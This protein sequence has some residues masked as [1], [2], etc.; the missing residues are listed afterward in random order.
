M[1]VDINIKH[2]SFHCTLNGSN[3]S[4]ENYFAECEQ[5][6]LLPCLEQSY[7][8]FELLID[9]HAPSRLYVTYYSQ[10][11]PPTL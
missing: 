9:L 8:D 3:A 10:P 7:R 1:H 11:F 4:S 6:I 5:I 2:L